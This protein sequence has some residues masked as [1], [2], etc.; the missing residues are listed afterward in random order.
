VLVSLVPLTLLGLALLGSFGLQDVWTNSL[1]PTIKAPVTLPVYRGIDFSVKRIFDEDTIGL[2]VFAAALALWNIS[3][4]MRI[5]MKALNVIHDTKESRSGRRLVA[6]DVALAL[7]IGL[8]VIGAFLL[9]VT[10]PRLAG[11][12]LGALLYFCA[13]AGAA[14]LLA[15]GIGLVMHYAPA[16]R[17]EASWASA[18]SVL[19]VVTWIIASVAF[20][21]WAGSV[22]NYKSATGTLLVFLLLTTYVLMSTTVFL[23]G[24]QLDELARKGGRR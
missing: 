4:G 11:G 2:I 19:V 22:A 3:R 17:P 5:V 12:L 9:V 14:L 20:G 21:F 18:G 1:G 13:W 8:C 23:A 24:A 6:T 16:E 7:A 15:V 10:V